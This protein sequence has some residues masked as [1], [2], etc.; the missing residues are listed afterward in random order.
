MDFLRER[1]EKKGNLVSRPHPL[2]ET[3]TFMISMIKSKIIVI[4]PRARR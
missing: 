3:I 1:D 4:E 2:L